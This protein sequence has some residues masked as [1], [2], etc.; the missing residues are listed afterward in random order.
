MKELFI[1]KTNPLCFTNRV[2]EVG[3]GFTF[4]GDA[5]SFDMG[6]LQGLDHSL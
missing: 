2:A 4:L 3:T 6:L 5:G 1:K